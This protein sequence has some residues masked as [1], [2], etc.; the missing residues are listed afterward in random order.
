L[1][2]RAGA[3]Q[4]LARLVVEDR[5]TGR[6]IDRHLVAGSAMTSRSRAAPAGCRL[7]VVLEAEVAE[8]RLARVDAD[9]DRAAASTVTA[10]GAAARNVSLGAERGCSVTARAGLD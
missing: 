9:V 1:A 2:D 5:G 7:E 4:Q 8:R 3:G 6:A 10:V